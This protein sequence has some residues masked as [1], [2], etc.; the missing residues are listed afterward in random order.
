MGSRLANSRF[1]DPA[2]PAPP[3]R[4]E[5]QGRSRKSLR[6]GGAIPRPASRWRNRPTCRRM[7]KGSPGGKLPRQDRFAKSGSD[8][9]WFAWADS[10]LILSPWCGLCCGLRHRNEKKGAGRRPSSRAV[11]PA[12]RTAIRCVGAFPCFGSVSNRTPSAYFAAGKRTPALVRR[13][14]CGQEGGEF[15]V[16]TDLQV[17]PPARCAG[18]QRQSCGTIAS[19]TGLLTMPNSVSTNSVIR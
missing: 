11:A 10:G 3:W 4:S 14:A 19:R 6:G 13:L 5:R 1:A 18:F 15:R 8:S 17:L 16:M 2:R 7:R 12:Q 9:S